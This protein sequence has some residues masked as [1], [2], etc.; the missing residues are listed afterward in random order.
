[1]L[2]LICVAI[3][4]D[5]VLLVAACALVIGHV[6]HE[7]DGW[8]LEAVEHLDSFDH[9]NV[10]QSL[11]CGDDDSCGEV[12]LLAEGELNVTSAWWKIYDKVVKVPPSCL[13]NELDDEV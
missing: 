8:D 13:P 7:C 5:L 3:S 1:M 10:A 12:K 2:D 4:K 11:W 6:G 9:V